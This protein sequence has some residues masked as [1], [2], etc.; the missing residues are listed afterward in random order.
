[1]GG[2]RILRSLS[3]NT[4]IVTTIVVRSITKWDISKL[5][6]FSISYQAVMDLTYLGHIRFG[7]QSW[8]MLC[9]LRIL[10]VCSGPSRNNALKW[11]VTSFFLVLSK[12]PC[13]FDLST[14]SVLQDLGSWYSVVKWHKNK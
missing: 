9:W 3:G 7:S 12:P 10:V 8:C 4:R 14:N 2:W 11:F 5:T 1:L 13:I 6:S